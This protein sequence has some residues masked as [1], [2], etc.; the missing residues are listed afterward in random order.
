MPASFPQIVQSQAMALS[1]RYVFCKKACC[2]GVYSQEAS[3][4]EPRKRTR[5]ERSGLRTPPF[6][7]PC[8]RCT[9][10]GASVRKD[11]EEKPVEQKG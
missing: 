2:F 3:G 11:G 5:R 9:L 8:R 1:P 6:W 4:A 10:E 7:M